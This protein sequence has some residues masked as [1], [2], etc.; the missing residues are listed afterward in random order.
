MLRLVTCDL[1]LPMLIVAS[2]RE[3]AKC[4][5]V[6]SMSQTNQEEILGHLSFKVRKAVLEEIEYLLT[7]KSKFP[8]L[9]CTLSKDTAW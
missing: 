9:E 6:Q 3:I 7:D 8:Y 4:R 5:Y 1:G 2:D